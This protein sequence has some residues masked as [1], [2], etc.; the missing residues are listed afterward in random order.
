MGGL[1]SAL[2]R[3]GAGLRC[4]TG[5]PIAL[6]FLAVHGAWLEA[7]DDIARTATCAT[8]AQYQ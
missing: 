7:E 2:K 3:H 5:S 1:G 8:G 4:S 6:S